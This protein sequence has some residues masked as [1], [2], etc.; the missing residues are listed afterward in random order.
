MSTT[1]NE[2]K[3]KVL[4]EELLKNRRSVND[5]ICPSYHGVHYDGGNCRCDND[6]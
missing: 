5:G 6:E 1:L 4:L 2:N 3:L